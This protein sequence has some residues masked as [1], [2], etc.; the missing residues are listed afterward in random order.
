MAKRKERESVLPYIVIII[1]GLI[2][3]GL[4]LYI[5]PFRY[6]LNVSVDLESSDIPLDNPLT[7]YAPWG[8]NTEE[9]EDS[10]LVYIQVKWSDWEPEK[11]FYDIESLEEK[12]HIQRWKSEHKN[13]VLRF[14]C[15]I[16][17]DEEHMD[18]PAYLYTAT[19]DGVFYDCRY[20]KG[21]C[22]NYA[23]RYFRERHTAAIKALADYCNRDSF[24]AYVELG[25]LGHWGEWHTN[26]AEGAL[27]LPDEEI[28]NEY[29]LAYSDSFK[30]ARLL[31]RRN[32]EIAVD[33]GL[34]LYNDMTGDADDTEEWL[35]WTRSGGE[36]HTDGEPLVFK[37]T[38][39]FWEKAPVGGEI[40]GDLSAEELF[41]RWISVMDDC[42]SG[43]HLS[44]MGP[45]CPSGET[46]DTKNAQQIREKMGY[47]Y[48]ISNLTTEYSFSEGD[49]EVTMK[50]GNVGLAPI[51][52][53]WPVTMYV[54]DLDGELTYWESVDIDLSKLAPGDNAETLSHIPFTDSFRKGYRIGVGITSPDESVRARL[55]MDTEYI[56]GVQI[57]YTFNPDEKVSSD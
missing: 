9:C 44:F 38:E 47:R 15:D 23:N 10:Q 29:I 46:K 51:Y 17:D 20:G 53:E 22:P 19:H 43:T 27:P 26:T 37:P 42:V 24:V 55:A 11:D 45:R 52:W 21:Y 49:L 13:A 8:E 16:P 7:G 41:G 30:N 14:V 18:I 39:R 4:L 50:G 32:Y 34:G 25:S 6:G 2:I 57:I 48:Y 36:Y 5:I 33:G 1:L 56:D 28:C 40:G 35:E 31:T 3:I 12:Y 54:Y